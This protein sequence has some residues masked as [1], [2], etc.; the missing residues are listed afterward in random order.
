M[1]IIF[2]IPSISHF[3]RWLGGMLFP[4]SKL[5]N[6]YHFINQLVRKVKNYL[7]ISRQTL[8]TGMSMKL[9]TV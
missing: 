4:F 7:N 1:Q 2:A 9:I 8:N 5:R 3:R 6:F